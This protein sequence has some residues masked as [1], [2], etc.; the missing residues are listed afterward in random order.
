MLKDVFFADNSHGWSVGAGGALLATTDGGSS[1]V[2]QHVR[3]QVELAAVAFSDAAN[4]WVAA[5]RHGLLVTRDGG[6]TWAIVRLVDD[7]LLM[8][9][10]AVRLA[11]SQQPVP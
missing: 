6:R 7:G 8:G 9:V 11:P 5:E 10:T 4:G 2:P 3:Q 1:W